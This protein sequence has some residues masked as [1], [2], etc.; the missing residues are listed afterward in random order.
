[1]KKGLLILIVMAL[2]SCS[3]YVEFRQIDDATYLIRTNSAH[4]AAQLT[5]G[6][7]KVAINTKK[8]STFGE[9]LDFLLFKSA[10]TETHVGAK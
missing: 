4:V 3:T 8:Q 2:S 7:V 10:T 9:L 1:M 5:Q 6:E